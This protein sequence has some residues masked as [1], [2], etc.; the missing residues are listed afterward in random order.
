MLLPYPRGSILMHL[1]RRFATV[2]V[3]GIDGES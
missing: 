1:N 3:L 2:A